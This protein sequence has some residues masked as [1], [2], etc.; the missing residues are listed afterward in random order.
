[1]IKVL[2]GGGRSHMATAGRK[3]PEKIPEVFEWINKR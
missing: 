1:L 2:S 3:Y